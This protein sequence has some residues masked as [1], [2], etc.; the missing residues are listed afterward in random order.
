MQKNILILRI[1]DQFQANK[2]IS[3]SWKFGQVAIILC[4]LLRSSGAG[5]NVDPINKFAS[6]NKS[7]KN[8]NS[9]GQDYSVVLF[10]APLQ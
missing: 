3:F 10:S 8:F 9:N 6:Q 5:I 4:I 1:R 7:V 2:V